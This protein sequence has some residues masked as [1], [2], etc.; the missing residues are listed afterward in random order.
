MDRYVNKN[1]IVNHGLDMI[2]E[3]KNI[4]RNKKKIS[5]L[6]NKLNEFKSIINSKLINFSPLKKNKNN[7]FVDDMLR[8]LWFD[9]ITKNINSDKEEKLYTMLNYQD[10]TE[11]TVRF[12]IHDN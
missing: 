7:T 2:A 3:I 4:D 1:S 8:S 11:K 9:F 12:Q 10:N 6:D 5:N